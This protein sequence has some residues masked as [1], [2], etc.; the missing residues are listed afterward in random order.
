MPVGT[1]ACLKISQK[2]P[3]QRDIGRAG[4]KQ[5]DSQRQLHALAKGME[6]RSHMRKHPAILIPESRGF[7]FRVFTSC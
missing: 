6:D 7:F 5:A 2:S 4:R 3:Y 1:T